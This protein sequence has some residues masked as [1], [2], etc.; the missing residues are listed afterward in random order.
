MGAVVQVKWNGRKFYKLTIIE[1]LRMTQDRP[2]GKD[3]FTCC[4]GVTAPGV[5]VLRGRLHL[6]RAG[7]V[8]HCMLPLFSFNKYLMALA[9]SVQ[10]I[11]DTLRRVTRRDTRIVLLQFINVL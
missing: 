4:G 10:Y 7:I 6:L 8:H 9:P 1:A 11:Q 5:L 2:E 3:S